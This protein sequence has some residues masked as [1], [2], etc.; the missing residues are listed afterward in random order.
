MYYAAGTRNRAHL[1]EFE[2]DNV[3]MHLESEEHAEMVVRGLAADWMAGD[4]FFIGIFEKATSR[5]C[6]QVYVGPT[7]WESPEF[8][9]GFVANVHCEGKGYISE[10]VNGVLGMLFEDLAAYL[11]KSECS[12][13]NVRSRRLLERCGF[14]QEG[15]VPKD[16]GSKD[17]STT[18]DCLY[19]LSRHEYLNR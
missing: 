9:I 17:G 3:L 1:T 15:Y 14:R 10:A 11:I 5:W 12:E 4:C 8:T 2:A 16:K 7:S 19:V 6:G 18:R 13:G